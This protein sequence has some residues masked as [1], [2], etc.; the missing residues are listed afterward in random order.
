[1]PP[2][3]LLSKYNIVNVYMISFGID[4]IG[5]SRIECNIYHIIW[6]FTQ[7]LSINK[8]TITIWYGHIY[9]AI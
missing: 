7:V 4:S 5:G 3:L 6:L 9:T 2:L 1:M 8:D